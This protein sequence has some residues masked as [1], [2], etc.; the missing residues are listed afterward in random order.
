MASIVHR[1]E[2]F[3]NRLLLICVA[4]VF[5][6]GCGGATFTNLGNGVGVPTGAIDDYAEEYG[7]SRDE[8]QKRMLAESNQKRQIRNGD[9]AAR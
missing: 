1:M 4:I 9:A 3:M 8:A 7:I 5:I 2:V 6:S